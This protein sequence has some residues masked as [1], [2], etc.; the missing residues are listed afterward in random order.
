MEQALELSSKKNPPSLLAAYAV[1]FS[2]VHLT[3]NLAGWYWAYWWFDIVMHVGGGVWVAWAAVW[4]AGRLDATRPLPAWITALG[5]LASVALVGVLW[6][7]LEAVADAYLILQAAPFSGLV[8]G[9]G[10]A[11]FNGRFDSLLDLFN[12]LVGGAIVI[13]AWLIGRRKP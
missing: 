12:D 2:I 1:G 11:P 7:L 6:E 10:E 3:A 9:F 4:M 13:A 5:V 8:D